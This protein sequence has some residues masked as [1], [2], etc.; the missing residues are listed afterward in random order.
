MIACMI[1]LKKKYLELS[2]SLLSCSIDYI[3]C[4]YS[5]ILVN[6]VRTLIKYGTQITK[7]S[8]RVESTQ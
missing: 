5:T 7:R 3:V 2:Y 4:I 1:T 6:I 8:I